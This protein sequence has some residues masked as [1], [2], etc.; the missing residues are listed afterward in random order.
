LLVFSAV[1]GLAILLL[2]SPSLEA[3]IDLRIFRCLYGFGLG[4]LTF[5]IVNYFSGKIRPLISSTVQLALWVIIFVALSRFSWSSSLLYVVPVLFAIL[6]G[7]MAKDNQ[8]RFFL[9]WNGRVPTFLGAISYSIYLNH[10]V[11]LTAFGAVTTRLMP[12]LSSKSPDSL[13][14][15]M[16]DGLSVIFLATTV[17]LSFV[18]YKFI[19][20]PWRER[21]RRPGRNKPAET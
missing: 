15:W 16:G 14:L 11:L 21:G 12:S 4:V 5:Q 13:T 7:V 18:T 8:S 3:P 17:S 1:I 6:I 9:F 19:E 20:V 10:G 2:A